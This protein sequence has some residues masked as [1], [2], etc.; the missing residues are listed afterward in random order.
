[1]VG[2]S[3]DGKLNEEMYTRPLPWI[4]L[5]VAAASLACAIAMAADLIHGIRN[6]RFWFPTK[7]FSIN[8]TS[9]TI[10]TV[11]V[12]FS[13]DLNTP[14]PSRVDQL[15]KLSSGV[16]LCVVIANS[17]PSLG[18]VTNKEIMMNI[19][20]FAILVVTVFVNIAIQLITGVIYICWREH[21]A[22]MG[23]M[24][25]MLIILGFSALAVP[26][27]KTE[28]E[29]KYKKRCDMAMQE[30]SK[31]MNRRTPEE[32]KE[33][34]MKFWI[35]AHTSSPQFVM[36]RSVTCT[37]SGALCL[38][39]AAVL[40]EAMLRSFFTPWSFEFCAGESDY[41][42]STTLVLISQTVAVGVG[43]VAP[44]VRWFTAV[45]F[46]CPRNGKKK[47]NN[48]GGGYF[49]VEKYWIQ[50]LVEFKECPFIQIESKQ[51]RKVAHD[52]KRRFFDTCIGAQIGI[53]MVCKLIQFI[54]IFCAGRIVY[55]CD[56]CSKL[57][58]LLP[59]NSISVEPGIERRTKDEN[60]IDLSRFVLH[61]E[62]EDELVE[63][64]MRKNCTATAHWLQKGRK[65]KPKH[66]TN[67]LRRASFAE[68]F[69]GVREF[70]CEQVCSLECNEPP[71]CW[72]LPIVTLTAIAV[73]LPNVDTHSANQLIRSVHEGLVYVRLV[74]E[75]QDGREELSNVIRAAFHVWAGVDI[76][77]KWC[78]VDLN[79]LSLKSETTKEVLEGLA[80]T[81]K[82]KLTEFRKSYPSQ[83][84]RE[85]PSEW[86]AKA[87]AANSMYRISSTILQNHHR[88]ST[89]SGE[90]LFATLSVLISDILAACLTNLR[91][92][93][94]C[95]C[96]KSTIEERKVSVREAVYLLGETEE[97]VKLLDK[98]TLSVVY[99]DKISS[100]GDW[101]SLHK[102][103][104]PLAII[105]HP[106]LDDA[107]LFN[108]G[109][110]YLAID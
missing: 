80:E 105:D 61:L 62:G 3:A 13:V 83:C 73:A 35:M 94:F 75:H 104:K 74:E 58:S 107:D 2:C 26:T 55:V 8:A 87:L 32:L 65:R 24:L 6:R 67:L 84:P 49:R 43:T 53:V 71:H 25:L 29:F 17:M 37:A 88:D 23:L 79:E 30:G 39:G 51:L 63:M 36:G 59:R 5:Y 33:D 76:Y 45:S 1:M 22:V 64:T 72:S 69:K 14:M 46:R 42:W 41:K 86:H 70:D 93:I 66:L 68:G 38:L 15:T 81:G 97:I 91:P 96:L 54:S 98:S 92:V 47:S 7:F 21:V 82:N 19:I 18:T 11:A 4:G 108:V 99:C 50:L 109:D 85:T 57:K 101:H 48:G 60:K 106:A 89:G 31:D 20:A 100:V 110:T 27:T 52:A 12:K 56:S 34:L 44:A 102:A 16:L 78:G 103:S 10:I 90:R 77:H 40:G 95:K 9:L 28:L